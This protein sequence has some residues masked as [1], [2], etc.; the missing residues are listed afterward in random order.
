VPHATAP[1]DNSAQPTISRAK[2]WLRDMKPP[3]ELLI[4]FH[5][6]VGF[7]NSSELFFRPEQ[8]RTTGKVVNH[9]LSAEASAGMGTAAVGARRL[10]NRYR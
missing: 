4:A 8:Y 9:L 7:L 1:I 5:Q 6:R 2:E 10:T 3:G